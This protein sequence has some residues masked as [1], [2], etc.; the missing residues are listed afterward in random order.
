MKAS[1]ILLIAMAAA[2]AIIAAYRRYVARNE[3]DF[4]HLEDPTGTL[5]RRQVQTARAL[6]W[7]DHVGIAMTIAT[8]VYALGMLIV[9]IYAG[10]Q[11]TI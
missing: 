4:L 3:D 10:L 9:F 8:A 2:T 11:K 7:I 6:S 5:V 1:M